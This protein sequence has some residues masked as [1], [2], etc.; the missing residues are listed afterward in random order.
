[1][2]VVAIM[3]AS[4]FG[5]FPGEQFSELRSWIDRGDGIV[6]YSASGQYAEELRRS[7]TMKEWL[8]RYRRSNAAKVVSAD[9]ID[10]A[11]EMLQ[12]Q[13]IR[14]ND[15]HILALAR[16]S[17]ALVLASDDGDLQGDFRD[18]RLLP[19]IGRRQRSVYP[20]KQSPKKQRRFLHGRRC[21]G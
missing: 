6:V 19:R 9:E 3:D 14:S 4:V 13:N 12:N 5:F 18:T 11:D 20:M 2:C 16:A 15:R 8:V 21:S 17:N 10:A 1:M 7:G